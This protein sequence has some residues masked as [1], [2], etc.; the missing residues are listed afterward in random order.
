MSE[1]T[2]PKLQEWIVWGNEIKDF[3]MRLLSKRAIF[4][5]YME[6]VKTNP[7]IQNPDDFHRWA[8]VNYGESVASKIRAQLDPNG[9]TIRRLLKDIQRHPGIITRSWYTSMYEPIQLNE[10]MMEINFGDSD[11][12]KVGGEGDT[13][14]VS[15]AK[16]DEDNLIILGANI[17]NYV[18]KRIAHNLTQ[19]NNVKDITM[20]EINGF[21]DKYEEIVIKYIL[22]FTASGHPSLLPTWQYDWEKIFT[23]PWIKEK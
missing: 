12:S 20:N 19:V 16:T 15:I 23:K 5:R 17:K 18:D 8:F 3:T 21:I 1:N 22:L 7:E 6:I 9:I 14:D 13:F 10:F 2:S 4:K 11:F